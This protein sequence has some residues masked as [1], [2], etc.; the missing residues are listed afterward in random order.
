M[1]TKLLAISAIACATLIATSTALAAP[2]GG[3]EFTGSLGFTSSAVHF[4]AQYEKASTYSDV[5]GYFFL[6]TSKEKSGVQLV[7]QVMSFGGQ[8]KVHLSSGR[9]DTYIAP[10]V[11]V[12]MIKDIQ[13]ATTGK[14]DDVTAVGPTMRVGVLF[15][16][17]S[18]MKLGLERLDIVNWF[19]DKA[20]PSMSYYAAA[21]A[22]TF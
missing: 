2:A 18:T 7:N 1:M 3:S 14:K 16:M 5:G 9:V 8:M 19:D 10:G 4:S 20:V 13:D 17:S 11:G 12:H 15:P 21:M 6:Q 22:F